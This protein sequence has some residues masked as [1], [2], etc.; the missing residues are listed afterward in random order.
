LAV[1][2]GLAVLPAGWSGTDGTFACSS[3]GAGVSCQLALTYQ[4]AI[5]DAGTLALGFTYTN[6]SGSVKS[7]SIVIPYTA[8]APGP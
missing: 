8:T 6:D 7:G 3:L 5:P 2:S 1:T 4:P